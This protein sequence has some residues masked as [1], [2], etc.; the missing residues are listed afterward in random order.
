M[1]THQG[2]AYLSTRQQDSLLDFQSFFFEQILFHYVFN[3]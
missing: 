1:D 3:K 2:R